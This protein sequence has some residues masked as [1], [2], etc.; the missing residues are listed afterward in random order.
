MSKAKIYET[1]EQFLKRLEKL[2]YSNR[3]PLPKEYI[4]A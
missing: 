2:A 1:N 4:Q 3:K